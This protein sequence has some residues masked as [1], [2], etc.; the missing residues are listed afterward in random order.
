MENKFLPTQEFADLFG[1][2]KH[3]LFHYDKM[4]IFKP[5]YVNEKGYRFY[6]I[7]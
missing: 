3:T 1:I 4:N 7:Y 5:A 2:T 6:S